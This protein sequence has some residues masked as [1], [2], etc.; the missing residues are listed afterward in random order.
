EAQ[1]SGSINEMMVHMDEKALRQILLNLTGNALKFT[2][3][4]GVTIRYGTSQQGKFVRFEVEDTGIGIDS[5]EHETVFNAFEQ[6]E[7]GRSNAG[8]TGLGLAISKRLCELMGGSIGMSS[9]PGAGSVFWFELPLRLSDAPL[10]VI[11]ASVREIC[12]YEGK[13]RYVLVVDDNRDNREVLSDLLTQVGFET[14][15][16]ENGQQAWDMLQQRSPDIILTDLVMPQMSGFELCRYV[17]EKAE[18]AA[19]PVV[20]VSASLMRSEENSERLKPFAAFISKPILVD[21]LYR[22]VGEILGLTW[23]YTE[24]KTEE[25]TSVKGAPIQ[26]PD[27]GTLLELQELAEMGDILELQRRIAPL[28]RQYPDREEYYRRIETLANEFQADAIVNLIQ[29][30]LGGSDVASTLGEPN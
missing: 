2:R 25:P 26:A 11:A 6:A 14:A 18:F 17:Q 24:D 5:S 29:Q 21:E 7:K 30:T 20:A 13:K 9:V 19:L 3:V 4:G 22:E 8:G 10:P 27:T 15:T 12:G 23:R 16:A 1:Q 28:I